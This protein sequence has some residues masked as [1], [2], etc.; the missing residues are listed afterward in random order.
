[1]E[2]NMGIRRGRGEG[3][4]QQ[5]EDGRWKAWLSL[6]KTAVGKR[7]RKAVYGK[8]KQEVQKKL[9]ELLGQRDRGLLADC[10]KLTGAEGFGRW[11]ALVK[12]DLADGTHE[13]YEGHVRNHL[14]PHLGPVP[15]ARLDR[16]QVADLYQRLA[17]AGVS[18]AMRAKLAT[19]LRTS[20]K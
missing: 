17:A 20:L 3:S 10:G 16:L 14:A 13:N 19:T 1:G 8:T 4:I 7:R 11:L 15:L 6:G 12:P 5:L 9:R 18:D 2:M